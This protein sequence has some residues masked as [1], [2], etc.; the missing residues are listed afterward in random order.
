MGKAVSSGGSTGTVWVM[1]GNVCGLLSTVCCAVAIASCGSSES[2][3]DLRPVEGAG[4]DD[5]T[6]TQPQ[7]WDGY[8]SGRSGRSIRV[9]YF[10][11][12]SIDVCGV[13]LTVTN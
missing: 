5:C 2:D 6:R 11:S 1:R 4:A 13:D 9:I 10:T 8:E 3:F 7:S 12:R